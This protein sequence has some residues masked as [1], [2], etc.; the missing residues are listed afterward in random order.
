M[1]KLNKIIEKLGLI[2]FG[3]FETTIILEDEIRSLL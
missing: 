1:E 3:K 2:I